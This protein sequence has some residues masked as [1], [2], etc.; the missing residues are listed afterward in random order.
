MKRTVK[1]SAL[2]VALFSTTATAAIDSRSFAMGGTGVSNA[3][4]LTSSFHNPA[5]AARYSERDDFGMILPTI[6]VRAHDS[7]D[8]VSSVDTFIDA[9]DLWE[10]SNGNDERAREEWQSTLASMDGETINADIST[11]M[12]IAIP[13]QYLSANLFA[14]VN[15]T[16]FATPDVDNNDL[17][18]TSTDEDLNSR[19]LGLGA[20]TVDIGL[21][22]AR[23][24]DIDAL[25]GRL[26]LGVSPKFQQLVALGYSAAIEDTDE[27]DFDFDDANTSSGFNLDIGLAYD[28][29]DNIQ[30]GFSAR[31]LLEQTLETNTYATADNQINTATYVVGPEFVIGAS[32]QT[33]LFSVSADVDLN[34]KEYFKEVD[35]ATQYA[36]LG[37]EFD[38]W[39]WA[40]V[41]AGYSMSMNDYAED[42]VTAGLGVKLFGTAGLDIS[43]GYGSDNNYGVA[44]QFILQI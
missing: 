23:E 4:Y 25:P 40:Q 37:A 35:Y 18:I 41:R 1:L 17:N 28:V 22:L 36:R 26:F 21:T 8:L 13:N 10:D 20:G 27:E 11:G 9:F 15:L 2:A 6:N 32:Y 30:L 3:N 14:T 44:A 29:N 39:S 33:K 24:L 31:N 16:A 12:V 43:A 42:M 5:L 7:S 38:A 19:V 34:E